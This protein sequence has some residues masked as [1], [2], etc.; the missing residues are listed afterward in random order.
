MKLTRHNGRI[1]QKGV[2][3]PKHNDRRFDLENSSH[4]DTDRAQQNIFWDCY[5]GYTTMQNRE[6]SDEYDATFEEI[7]RA[8]YTEHYANFVSGQNARNEKTRHTERN[9]SIEQ[10]LKNDKTCPEETVFQIGTMEQ[11]VQPEI[12]LS[13]VYEFTRQF[14]ER[15]GKHVHILDWALHLDESTPHIHERHVFDCENRYGEVCPQQ[16]KALEKLEIPLPDPDKPKGK[17]NNRK[18]TFAAICRTMLFDISREYGLHLDQKPEYGGR[19]YLEK[20]DFLLLKQKEKLIKQEAEIS[21]NTGHLDNQIQKITEVETLID[22]VSS[23]AYDKAVEVV[24]DTVRAETQK[25]DIAEIERYQKW[26][27]SPER[28]L[29]KNIREAVGECLGVVQKKL[30]NAAKK[31]AVTVRKALLTPEAHNVGKAQVKEKT[32]ESITSILQRM[33]IVADQANHDRL[34]R[35]SVVHAKSEDD[36]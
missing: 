25:A 2:Y 21:Q 14:E 10:I 26:I 28:K 3:N 35:K 36:R 31:I 22:A 23:A 5:R 17:T 9:R 8:Y 24:A 13:V 11:A 33:K 15:F 34:N 6:S 16:E 27:T 20:Q 32:R 7:E 30:M 1:G 4:I 12:L 29:P 18:M 19:A